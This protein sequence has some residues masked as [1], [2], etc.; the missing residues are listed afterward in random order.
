VEGF[1][2]AVSNLL[3][4][5]IC[6]VAENLCEEMLAL[7]LIEQMVLSVVTLS[8]LVDPMEIESLI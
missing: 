1:T 5:H 4:V 8:V 6:A 3:K 7:L 2:L